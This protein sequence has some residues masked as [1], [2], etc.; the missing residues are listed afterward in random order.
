MVLLFISSLS[1]YL[2]STTS[3]QML[4]DDSPS[5]MKLRVIFTI[6]FTK[7]PCELIY[8]DNQDLLGFTAEDVKENIIK[9]RIVGG[10][11]QPADVSNTDPNIPYEA[12]KKLVQDGEGCQLEGSLL[13]NKVPGN[14][15][16]SVHNERM[17]QMLQRLNSEG[18]YLNFAHKIKH[19][20]FGTHEHDA[21]LIQRKFPEIELFP[22]EGTS[23]DED[24][25]L[26]IAYQYYLNVVRAVVN[27]R[28]GPREVYQY[29]ISKS[30]GITRD[31]PALFFKYE[32]SPLYVRYELKEKSIWHFIVNICA[33]IGG[34]YTAFSILDA[35]IY[36]SVS[37][38]FKNRIGKLS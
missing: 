26:S 16:F 15:H 8:T 28:G 27:L 9:R 3:S 36:S 2:T 20:S 31:M 19:F 12:L 6:D 17:A 30:F 32:M 22:L 29:T 1:E 18:V 38:I 23:M 34:V 21:K 13:V 5:E 4:I 25:R 24:I 35:I 14:I 10:I 7:V 33:I 37:K 11:V